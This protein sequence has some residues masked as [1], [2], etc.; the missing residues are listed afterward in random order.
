MSILQQL[1]NHILS[2]HVLL[3]GT[4]I[5]TVSSEGDLRVPI[6]THSLEPSKSPS[7]SLCYRCDHVQI[8]MQGCLSQLSISPN[9]QRWH[10][11]FGRRGYTITMSCWLLESYCRSWQVNKDF[12]SG[13]S[14]SGCSDHFSGREWCHHYHFPLHI[15]LNYLRSCP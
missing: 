2:H 9:F 4:C 7:R 6:K 14:S 5:L 1:R 11:L 12:T 15:L 8:F 13:A 10:V 3:M